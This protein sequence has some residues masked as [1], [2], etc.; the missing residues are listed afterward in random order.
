MRIAWRWILPVVPLI[1]LILAGLENYHRLHSDLMEVPANVRPYLYRGE[2]YGC[3]P[4]WNAREDYVA[5][6]KGGVEHS[7]TDWNECRPSTLT[8]F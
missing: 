2:R 7:E 1:V 6:Q 5:M 8:M 3:F 4:L